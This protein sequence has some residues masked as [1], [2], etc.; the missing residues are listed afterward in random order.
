MAEESVS[1]GET[2]R[3]MKAMILAA[4]LGTRLRPLTETRPKALV[5]VD[6][7]PLLE[8]VLRRLLEVGVTEVI[9]NVHHFPEQIAEFLRA[10]QNFGIR[11]ELSHESELLDTG[12]GL[13]QAGWFFD[14]GQPFFLHNVD[15]L[16]DIDLRALYQAHTQR[17]ALATL[18][19][20][21]RDSSRYLLFDETGRLCGWGNHATGRHELSREPDGEVEALGFCGIH[22]ISPAI[23]EKLTEAGAF[24]IITS[25]LRLA[26]EDERILAFRVDGATWR[27][28]GKL[29]MLQ[30]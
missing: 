12:G 8:H 16:S 2:S 5:E 23:F 9:V 1:L 18:A 21:P 22:V 13:K 29:E 14:D 10:K 11:I 30:R 20:M 6:G 25:Y 19:V 26:A 27:D 17:R 4:G 7:K 28:V 3:A 24:S 15:I